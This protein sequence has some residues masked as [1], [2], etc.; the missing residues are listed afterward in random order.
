MDLQIHTMQY[1]YAAITGAQIGHLKNDISAFKT[2][3]HRIV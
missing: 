1:G 2:V 3:G